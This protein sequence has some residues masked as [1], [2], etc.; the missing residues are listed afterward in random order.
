MNLYILI[1]I[2][3]IFKTKMIK[4]SLDSLETKLGKRKEFLFDTDLEKL[5]N[6][7]IS[8]KEKC[9]T[10]IIKLLR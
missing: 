4:E 9:N 5:Q 1:N 2:W 6:E 3:F 7:F 8:N 10:K